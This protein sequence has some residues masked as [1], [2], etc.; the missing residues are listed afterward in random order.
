MSADNWID[1]PKCKKNSCREDWDIGIWKG[2]FYV[3]FSAMCTEDDCDFSY[4]YN[5]THELEIPGDQ[6]DLKVGG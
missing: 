4:K 6:L 5:Y 2:E 1:C 3:K